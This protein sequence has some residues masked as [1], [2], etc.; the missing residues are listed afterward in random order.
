MTAKPRAHPIRVMVV[1]DTS[2]VRDM[3]TA[4]MHT[5]GDIEV[6]GTASNGKDA[7][8]IVKRIH[9]DIVT[10]DIDMPQMNGMEAIQHIMR[11][12]PTRII[13]VSGLMHNEVELTFK[14]IQTGAVTAIRT[15]KLSDPETCNQL[16]QTIRLMADVPVVHRWDKKKEHKILQAMPAESLPIDERDFRDIS[17]IG[18]AAS[19]GGPGAVATILRPLSAHFSIPILVVQHVTKGFATGMAN[20]LNGET[21]LKVSLAKSGD[22]PHSGTVLLAPDDQ[23][24]SV[25]ANGRVELNQQAPYK[26]L[27]PSANYLFHSLARY[28]GPRALGIILTGMGDDGAEGLKAMR[29]AGAKTIAQDEQSSVVFGMPREAILIEAAGQ[30]CSLEQIAVI[31]KDIGQ[32]AGKE[33]LIHA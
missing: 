25:T 15:P 17:I 27:R 32:P 7:I 22:I 19:T 4:I 30:V 33:L 26:S 20:W 24:M 31:L 8:R 18:I 1:D 2:T 6:V 13:V 29:Q 28:Y 14:A 5:A 21:K 23:H 11:E 12:A 16:I 9:P 3:L 10:M